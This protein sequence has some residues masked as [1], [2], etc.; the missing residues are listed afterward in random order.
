MDEEFPYPKDRTW[1][2]FE[3]ETREKFNKLF[4]FVI[5]EKH[6][7]TNNNK[8]MDNSSKAVSECRSKFTKKI[9]NKLGYEGRKG[10]GRKGKGKGSHRKKWSENVWAHRFLNQKSHTCLKFTDLK[11]KVRNLPG[12]RVKNRKV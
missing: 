7:L 12:D 9:S 3:D 6:A 4:Y 8:Y 2:N 10:E 11:Q 5:N 1:E